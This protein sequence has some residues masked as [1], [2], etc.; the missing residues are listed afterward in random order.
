[1]KFWLNFI[2]L[3]LNVYNNMVSYRYVKNRCYASDW[4]EV[5]LFDMHN[6]E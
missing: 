5:L 4:E 2:K 1:M 3:L 6:K